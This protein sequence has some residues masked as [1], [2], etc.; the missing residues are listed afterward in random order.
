MGSNK[1]MSVIVK[2]ATARI[3]F[4]TTAGTQYPIRACNGQLVGFTKGVSDQLYWNQ[5]GDGN[6]VAVQALVESDGNYVAVPIKDTGVYALKLQTF[7][8]PGNVP[9]FD[10][11]TDTDGLYTLTFASDD[12]KH[13]VLKMDTGSR[14]AKGAHGLVFVADTTKD[15]QYVGGLITMKAKPTPGKHKKSKNS[16]GAII[17]IIMG[18]IICLIGVAGLMYW[19][20]RAKS[21][22]RISI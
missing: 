7:V 16:T 14:C 11:T 8:D 3:L 9:V 17:G 4:Q 5:S 12:G 21:G 1:N 20:F 19:M 15:T 10:L 18:V 6:R 13:Y 2:M 22:P